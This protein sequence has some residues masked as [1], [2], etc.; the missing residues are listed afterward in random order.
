MKALRQKYAKAM[1]HRDE[2]HTHT[3]TPQEFGEGESTKED[4][5]IQQTTNPQTDLHC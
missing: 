5:H 3:H 2:A 4:N 1:S